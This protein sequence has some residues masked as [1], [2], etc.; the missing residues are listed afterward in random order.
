MDVSDPVS[1]K[2]QRCEL[3]RLARV[4]GRQHFKVLPDCR[5]PASGCTCAGLG[6]QPVRV[7]WQV[8]EVLACSL[9]RVIR[10]CAGIAERVEPFIVADQLLDPGACG[11]LDQAKGYFTND[12]VGP[13][14]PKPRRRR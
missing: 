8:Q 9:P 3:L 7:S 14:R 11:G 1:E 13:D 5:H 4:V 2:F 6:V 10:P 12:L